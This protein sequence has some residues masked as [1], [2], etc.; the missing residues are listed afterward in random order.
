MSH[1]SPVPL[2][3][4]LGFLLWGVV[5]IGGAIGT[6]AIVFH[7][8]SRVEFGKA[9]ILVVVVGVVICGAIA[10]LGVFLLKL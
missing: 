5:L 2:V 6:F 4:R 3:E 9:E 8:F 7:K 10:S 1:R